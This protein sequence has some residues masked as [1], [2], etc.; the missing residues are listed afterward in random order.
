MQPEEP[1]VAG[2]AP[3]KTAPLTVLRDRNVR[4]PRV[5]LRLMRRRCRLAAQPQRWRARVATTPPR[6]ARRLVEQSE[7]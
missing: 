7:A 4:R 3:I 1:V 5:D 2:R 6:P